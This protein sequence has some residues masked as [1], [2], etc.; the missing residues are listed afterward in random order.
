MFA[1]L[2]GIVSDAHDG[3]PDMNTSTS[4]QPANFVRLAHGGT[5]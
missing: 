5:H 2:D 3:E 4:G 1:A